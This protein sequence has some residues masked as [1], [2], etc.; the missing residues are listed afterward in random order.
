M[1]VLVASGVAELDEYLASYPAEVTTATS[2]EEVAVFLSQ[3]TVE[4]MPDVLVIGEPLPG[5]PPSNDFP[6][7]ILQ[8]WPQVKVLWLARPG[9]AGEVL[10]R[11]L[12]VGVQV[13]IGQV[14]ASE[15]M[16]AIAAVA[17]TGAPESPPVDGGPDVQSS[18]AKSVPQGSGGI[19]AVWS[20]K[21]EGAT[22]T[23]LHLSVALAKHQETLL[24]DMN[25]RRSML[26]SCLRG[27]D[28]AE[29]NIDMLYPQAQVGSLTGE[30]LKATVWRSKDLKHLSYLGG[31]RHPEFST[32]YMVQPLT[33]LL[34]L[35]A[36]TYSN[37]VVDVGGELDNA[38]TEAALSRADSVL[39]VLR[40]T[41]LSV[42]TYLNLRE[43]LTRL[44]VSV[45]NHRLVVASKRQED[46]YDEDVLA[47][48]CGVPLVA[49]LPLCPG[50]D[51][52]ISMG[53]LLEPG[54]RTTNQYWN[55]IAGITWAALRQEVKV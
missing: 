46:P 14:S 42:H 21:S 1:K 33:H 9:F 27:L 44:G 43:F 6:L 31:I 2:R 20:P 39:V 51:K 17:P 23:A 52:A 37:V 50:L 28:L 7:V 48:E 41:L 19:I 22:V 15:L 54:S 38:G 30:F 10:N 29:H 13:I 35:S 55:A 24:V 40:A 3:A 32:N 12:E 16:A 18:Q 8:Y 26:E 49:S 25:L 47:K 36:A 11:C 5:N 34:E 53:N 45:T 4:T